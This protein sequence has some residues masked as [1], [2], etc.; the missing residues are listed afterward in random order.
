MLK[1]SICI[2]FKLHLELFHFHPSRSLGLRLCIFVVTL[3]FNHITLW[4]NYPGFNQYYYMYRETC[5]MYSNN[6]SQLNYLG[7]G[8]TVQFSTRSKQVIKS[9]QKQ[10][11]SFKFLSNNI[12]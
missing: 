11:K 6:A 9:K 3:I 12:N 7:I 10:Y 2:L 5:Q 1:G 8:S 4:L